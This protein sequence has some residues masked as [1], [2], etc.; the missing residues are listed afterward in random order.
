MVGD[1]EEVK[2][3]NLAR[4]GAR[5]M[6][7]AQLEELG[8]STGLLDVDLF[9]GMQSDAISHLK[10]AGIEISDDEEVVWRRTGAFALEEIAIVKKENT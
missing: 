8:I 1:R 6:S 3:E 2:R 5:F 9:F 7:G 4:R 10:A